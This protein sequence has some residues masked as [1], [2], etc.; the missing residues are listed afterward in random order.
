M[1][2][3]GLMTRAKEGLDHLKVLANPSVRDVAP[4]RVDIAERD[5]SYV[6]RV[7]V[8][9]ATRRTTDV[10][11]ADDRTITVHARR[12]DCSDDDVLDWSR[13]IVLPGP[14]EDDGIEAT[15]TDGVLTIELP[16]RDGG[17]RRI[18]VGANP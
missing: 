6:V 3:Q 16:R 8:P 17:R 13:R 15:V 12:I 11:L 9:G 5:T 4:A 14:V 7:D 2:M 1:N 18:R 10:V